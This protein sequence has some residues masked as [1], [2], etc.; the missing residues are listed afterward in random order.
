L[1]HEEIKRGLNSGDACYLSAQNLMSFHMLS[2]NLE[3]G[4]HETIV[5]PVVLYVCETWFLTLK[6]EHRLRVFVNSV[7]RRI[8][9]PRGMK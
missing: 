4:M 1:I 7:L 3:I 9:E 6:D 2:I 8:L 5:L